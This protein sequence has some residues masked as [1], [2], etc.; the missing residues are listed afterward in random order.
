MD[1]LTKKQVDYAN[2]TGISKYDYFAN[3]Y[4]WEICGFGCSIFAKPASVNPN[5]GDHAPNDCQPYLERLVST[6]TDKQIAVPTMEDGNITI[7][8]G[9]KATS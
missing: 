9:R 2:A 6:H 3:P 8:Q 4:Q 5:M 7:S 1:I